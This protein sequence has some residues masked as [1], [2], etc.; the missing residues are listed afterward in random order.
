MDQLLIGQCRLGLGI[1]G[2]DVLLVEMGIAD[3]GIAGNDCPKYPVGVGLPEEL[4]GNLAVEGG[5]AHCK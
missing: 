5:I 4:E 1:E 2:K 3:I